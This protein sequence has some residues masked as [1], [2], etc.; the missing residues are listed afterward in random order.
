MPE[1]ADAWAR[2]DVDDH[3]VRRMT[4][5]VHVDCVWADE[6]GVP[7][8]D[9]KA[10]PRPRQIRSMPSRH[11]RTMASLRSTT[12]LKS[13]LTSPTWTPRRAAV[14]ATCA[15]RAL[16]TIV[17][18]GV[19]PVLTHV[20]PSLPRSTRS[21]RLPAA[22]SRVASGTPACPLPTIITSAFTMRPSHLVNRA[23]STTDG[24]HGGAMLA[25]TIPTTIHTD[26]VASDGSR[27]VG[28]PMGADRLER[29]AL[30]TLDA[31]ALLRHWA[32]MNFRD[33][34]AA[35]SPFWPKDRAWAAA[36]ASTAAIA[37]C[38]GAPAPAEEP[39]ETAADALLWCPAFKI[40]FAQKTGCQ[41]DGA[42]EFCVPANDLR[43]QRRLKAID[44]DIA[45][46]ASRGRAQCDTTKQLLG[47]YTLK[48]DA[49]V[50]CTADGAMTDATWRNVC[51]IASEWNVRRVVPT[52]YE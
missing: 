43:L 42:V 22:A 50:D 10:F 33:C 8:D 47:I 6:A 21:T 16:A 3:D 29:C 27:R 34:F 23:V 41:N 35:R 44:G 40:A 13:T 32:R 52:F 24:T 7:A 25:C 28:P 19:H 37:G 9:V 36:A 18:V 15:A 30:A 12:P 46:V 49:N 20:P 14:R 4:F 26:D 48:S 17:F 31:R 5:A 39:T 38:G 51:R 1:M 11:L 45:F 2:P